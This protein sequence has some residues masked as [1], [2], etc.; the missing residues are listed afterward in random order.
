MGITT[1][2]TRR[3]IAQWNSNFRCGDQFPHPNPWVRIGKDPKPPIFELFPQVVA[4]I[5]AY[6]V[7]H[8]DFFT[9][10]LLRNH[11]IHVMI[12]KLL[13]EIWNKVEEESIEYKHLQ[14]WTDK[15]LAH[16]T[17]CNGYMLLSFA[18]SQKANHQWLTST[19]TMNK[20]SNTATKP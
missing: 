14:T 18:I 2:K 11:L 10:E 16:M 17:V 4:D 12:P 9:V 8:L 3:T 5:N 20:I 6:V 15:S 13:E 7:Q 19:S 1:S